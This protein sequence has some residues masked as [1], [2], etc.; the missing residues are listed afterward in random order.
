[1]AE[2]APSQ[3]SQ[4]KPTTGT[5]H[6]FV[7]IG[8][9][10]VTI[11]LVIVAV[12]AA[13]R[14]PDAPLQGVQIYENLSQEHRNGPIAYEQTPP[15]GGP[16]D[17]AWQNCGVYEQPVRSE[18]VVHSM[19]HGAVWIAY[20]PGLPTEE[21]EQLRSLTSGNGFTLLAPYEE[22]PAPIVATAWGVQLQV[23]QSSDPQLASF[24]ADYSQGPQT[25][26]LGAPCTGGIGI[27][28]AR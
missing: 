4:Q 18:N 21:V 24:V 26:E 20:Q 3:P 14:Q 2:K 10:I 9:L 25:P 6:P 12:Y 23:G 19:E 27:P 13:G 17:P 11:M 1:M 28:V 15:V 22:I 7:W 16:H 8:I 5:T